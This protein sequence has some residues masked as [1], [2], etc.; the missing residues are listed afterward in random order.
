MTRLLGGNG[1]G[2]DSLWDDARWGLSSWDY[3]RRGPASVRDPRRWISLWPRSRLDALS[4]S[5][6]EWQVDGA[7]KALQYTASASDGAR[8]YLVKAAPWD[9][10]G[11]AES[12][13]YFSTGRP[14]MRAPVYDGVLWPARLTTP[15][16]T[17]VEVFSGEFG[18]ALP[19]FGVVQIALAGDELDSLLDYYWDGRDIW[20]YR[21]PQ[22]AGGVSDMALAF[23]GTVRSVSW[24]RT[25]LTLNLADYGEVVLKPAQTTLYLG[26]GGAEGG[27]DLLGK[28]KPMSFGKPRNVEPTLVSAAYLVFQVHSRA[29]AAI[30]AVYDRAVVLTASSDYASYATL[31][32][33]TVAAGSYATCLAEGL[34]R[35]GATPVGP[36]TV[37]VQGDSTGGLAVTAAD[38]IARIADD[39]TDLTS[40]DRDW[41]AFSALNAANSAACS[42]YVGSAESP[43]AADLFT[44]LMVSVG[45]FWTFTAERKLTVRQVAFSTAKV[46]ISWNYGPLA[47]DAVGRLETPPPYWRSKMG[48]SRAWRT[49]SETEVAAAADNGQIGIDINYEDFATISNGKAFIRGLNDAG[50][51]ADTDGWYPYG[52]ALVSVPR[53]QFADGSTLKTSQQADG[54]IIHDTDP[55]TASFAD[56]FAGI[57]GTDLT[58]RSPD[59]GTSWSD[60]SGITRKFAVNGLGQAAVTLATSAVIVIY[61]ANN[62]P[63]SADMFSEFQLDAWDETYPNTWGLIGRYQS[64]TSMYIFDMDKAIGAGSGGVNLGLCLYRVTGVSAVTQVGAIAQVR[65]AAGMKLRLSCV[66]TTISGW[67]RYPGEIMWTRVCTG[68]DA[69]IAAAGNG[70]IYT[71]AMVNAG[72]QTAPDARLSNYR[73]GVMSGSWTVSAEKPAVAFARY[74][75]GWQYDTGSAWASFTRKDSMVVLGSL[76]RGASSITT[77]ALTLP[78]RLPATE[79]QTVIVRGAFVRERQ[80]LVT[81]E[82]AAVQTRHRLAREREVSSLLDSSADATTENNRQHALLDAKWDVYRVPVQRSVVDDWRLTLG[83]TVLLRLNRFGLTGGK[84]MIIGGMATGRDADETVLTLWG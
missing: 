75:G 71:G 42:L 30:D 11:A 45:G 6:A 60:I 68:I 32:A 53:A 27:A 69:G 25:Q 55:V 84:A 43:S 44:A 72:F 51:R 64:A 17:A 19:T 50:A 39:F 26:T 48:Y 29:I 40:G 21:G 33:A 1:F 5:W 14:D 38:I 80:R 83:D 66:G 57:A 35:L 16:N 10:V 28:P 47:L 65:Y 9:P 82:S 36:V 56:Y 37:D 7:G 24:D 46:A 4:G 8:I 63:S 73:D 41:S 12:T 62:A 74:S 22:D 3:Y 59:T 20:V 79:A 15:M 52:G 67:V 31:T 58:A 78:Q 81:S 18:G 13:V 61:R 49:H 23:K 76:S 2:G 70:G 77:A 54:Y 34:V